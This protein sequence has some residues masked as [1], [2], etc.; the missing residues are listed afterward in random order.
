ME[1]NVLNVNFLLEKIF[2]YLRPI[3]LIC[4]KTVNKKFYDNIKYII[5][6]RYKKSHVFKGLSNNMSE[7]L[8]HFNNDCVISGSSVLQFLLNEKYDT[9]DIDIF[10]DKKNYQQIARC[11]F[12]HY[13]KI[14]S[15]WNNNPYS[16][17]NHYLQIINFKKECV[18]QIHIQLIITNPLSS[19]LEIINNF[20]FDILKNYYDGKNIKIC[21]PD[22]VLNKFNI[23][24]KS[25]LKGYKYS[26]RVEK[27]KNRGII[28]KVDSLEEKLNDLNL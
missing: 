18:N 16:K 23:I 28:F 2:D 24:E 9:F 21:K 27:F 13:Y 12:L 11:L 17:W 22:F 3:D 4:I 6:I 26:S 5:D 15:V 14:Q 25:K 1:T 20:D 10:V 7:F 8:N 19:P